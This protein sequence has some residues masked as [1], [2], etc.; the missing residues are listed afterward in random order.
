MLS[1]VAEDT[2]SEIHTL[3]GNMNVTQNEQSHTDLLDQL[4][5]EWISALDLC[6]LLGNVCFCFLLAFES[7]IYK[8]SKPQPFQTQ[9]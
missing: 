9:I 2:C 4:P 8:A 5:S 6:E 3:T 1:I 7:I